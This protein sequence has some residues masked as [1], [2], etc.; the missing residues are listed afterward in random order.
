MGQW[1]ARALQQLGKPTLQRT[2]PVPPT[3]SPLQFLI[4]ALFLAALGALW[5]WV[6][7]HRAGLSGRIT[8][9]RRISVAEV[10]ALSAQDRAMILN[11]DGKEFLVLRL[12]GCSAVVTALTGGA[13]E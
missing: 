1:L 5:F 13:G 4:V 10:A 8:R 11:V 2:A 6:Q 9:G 7:R 12:K 3:A